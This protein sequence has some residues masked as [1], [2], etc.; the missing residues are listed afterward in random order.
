MFF[1]RFRG[2]THFNMP[3]LVVH[4]ARD[5][6]DNIL[7]IQIPGSSASFYCIMLIFGPSLYSNRWDEVDGLFHS[8]GIISKFSFPPG[9]SFRKCYTLMRI[10]HYVSKTLV[11]IIAYCST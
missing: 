8:K 5:G 2:K 3:R 1:T 11:P 10:R 7:S 4:S 9:K 6:G